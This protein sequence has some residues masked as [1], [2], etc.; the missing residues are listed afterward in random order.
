MQK[1]QDSK[2]YKHLKAKDSPFIPMIDELIIYCEN[3]LP[4]INYVFI[5]Y[6]RHDIEHSFNVVEYMYH[7][8][9]DINLLSDYDITMCIYSALLHDIGM[10]SEPGEVAS[11]KS[12]IILIGGRKYSKILERIG[13]PHVAL[14]ECIRPYH[15]LRSKTHILSMSN[16]LFKLP[17]SNIYFNNELANICLSHNMPF[18]WIINETNLSN[19]VLKGNYEG[20]PSFVAVLLRLADYLDIDGQRTPIDLFNQTH[21][22]WFGLSEWK[23]NLSIENTSDNKIIYENGIKKVVIYGKTNDPFVHRK[24]LNYKDA[25]NKELE[26]S[27]EYCKKLPQKYSLNL[28][29]KIYD[30]VKSEGFTLSNLKLQLDYNSVTNLLMGEHI[31][32]DKK[33]GLREIIQNSID[34]CNVMQELSID[35]ETYKYNKYKPVISIILNKSYNKVLIQDNGIGMTMDIVRN[36]FL[37]VGVSYYNSFG[38]IDR[39]LD[40]LPI[41]K[42]GIG[43]LSCFML[44]NSVDVTTKNYLS[45][46]S[47][48]LSLV[49]DSDY[50]TMSSSDTQQIHGTSI[51]FDYTQFFSVFKNELDVESFIVSNFADSNIEFVINSEVHSSF[52][53]KKIN[54]KPV[55][56]SKYAI[57]LSKYLKGIEVR[58]SGILSKNFMLEDVND[59]ELE[60]PLMYQYSPSTPHLVNAEYEPIQS[61]YYDGYIKTAEVSLITNKSYD[62]FIVVLDAL[63]DIDD[64]VNKLSDRQINILIKEDDDIRTDSLDFNSTLINDYKVNYLENDFDHCHDVDTYV[65][66]KKISVFKSIS[67]EKFLTYTVDESPTFRWV[68]DRRSEDFVYVRN[69]YVSKVQVQIPY[70]IRGL[71]MKSLYVN[72]HNKKIFPDLSRND[73]NSE[74]KKK[75]NGSIG[76]ALH[77]WI[78]DNLKLTYE[79]ME[80]L[81]EFID[82]KYGA[83]EYCVD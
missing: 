71:K 25:L 38:F 31:Y 9:S 68:S 32:G 60:E 29:P 19:K 56:T 83:Q 15:A 70:I 51:E 77:L 53:S 20:S 82:I 13:D 78:M 48:M 46:T 10:T 5:D 59:L 7:L 6:T 50:I 73:I 30:Y 26:L 44:S 36:N 52:V 18:E 58:V 11:I 72:I 24:Y 21:L 57:D 62:D 12:D 43:F 67:T 74:I 37:N 54:L 40:Y 47:I 69:V 61:F 17:K 28:Y 14:Q 3:L 49:K 34:A 22:N 75:I 2:L 42:Y 66:I 76:K 79:E 8:I 4:R 16:D 33:Y 45:N 41:G 23:M 64:T 27:I 81:K 39:D 1:I 80:L 65:E 63:G 35:V 55:D